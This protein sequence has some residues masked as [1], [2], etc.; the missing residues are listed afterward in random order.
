[1]DLNTMNGNIK[2]IFQNRKFFW[3][4]FILFLAVYLLV[5]ISVFQDYNVSAD[6]PIQREHSRVAYKYINDKLFHREIDSMMN[7]EELTEYEHK[8]YGVSMQLPLVFIED[9]LHF[10]ISMRRIFQGRHLYNFLICV[11]GYIC[12][13]FAL[14]K[15]MGNRWYAL[16]G[17]AL[18]SLYPRFYAYQFYDIKNMIFAALNMAALLT[19]VNVVER[20]NFLNILLFAFVA[21]LTT[22]QRIMGVLF[23]VL[24]IGYFVVTDITQ[25]RIA[26]KEHVGEAQ[27]SALGWKKYPLIIFIYLLAW[28]VITPA[29]WEEPVQT[30]YETFVGFSNYE[31]WTG[32]MLFNGRLVTCEERPWYYLFVWFGI[33]IP[34]WYLVLFAAGHVYAVV[35][36]WK[37]ESKWIDILGKYKWLTCSLA[38]FWGSVGAVIILNSRIYEEWRH[39]FFVFVPFCCIA[40]YGFAFLLQLINKKAVCGVAAICLILQVVWLIG[41]HPYQSVYFNAIGRNIATKFDRDSWY[42]SNLEMLKWIADNDDGEQITVE[43]NFAD[44]ARLVMDDADRDRIISTKNDTDYI[45]ANYTR[46]VGNTLEIEGYEEVYSVWVDKYK[47]GSVFRKQER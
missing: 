21:A 45:L 31:R 26:H 20:C 41:N 17:M 35:S 13:Y 38:L 16:A 7:V 32:T 10:D 44:N 25:A 2:A 34:V 43:G 42:A 39:M 30:F 29:A 8:Y 37:S 14:K 9:C 5:G 3:L 18:I 40:V 12:F 4:I 33:S 22:N 27:P 19:L 46:V 15:I 6:E 36:V 11:L 1:M 47:I 24:L 23:P 28:F